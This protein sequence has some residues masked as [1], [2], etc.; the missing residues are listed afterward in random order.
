MGRGALVGIIIIVVIVLAALAWFASQQAQPQQPAAPT[1]AET[2][3]PAPTQGGPVV[4]YGQWAGVEGENFERAIS[5]Y[6]ESPVE[7]VIQEKIW[8]VV[9]QQLFAGNVQFDVALLPWPQRIVEL[10]ERGLL[11]PLDDVASRLEADLVNR[12][13]LEAVRGRDGSYYAVP[14]KMWAKPGI[15]VNVKAL[16][17][18]GLT[19][20]DVRTFEGLLAACEKLSA[21]GIQPLASGAADKWPLSDIWEHM[22][23]MLGGAELHDALTYDPAAWDRPEVRES[24]RLLAEMLKRGCF[25]DRDL[26]ISEKWEAQVPRLVKGEVAMYPMGNWITLFIAKSAEELGVTF[27]PGKDYVLVPWPSY[28]EGITQPIIAGGDWAIVP[29]NAPNKAAAIRFAE[30]LGGPEYQGA[31]VEAGG[32]LPTNKRVPSDV[33]SPVD[34]TILSLASER[35]V[36]VDL[37]DNIRPSE[38]QQEIWNALFELWANPDNWSQIFD[39]LKS[40][41]QSRMGGG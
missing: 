30:W 27:E 34:Q 25:G 40:T 26:R 22:L 28:R 13:F 38:L 41:V 33:M 39:G 35:G 15:W 7:Y 16:E 1:P 2:P 3:S 5:L 21:A 17:R 18:A 10:G 6:R 32:Y 19:P 36:V 23:I 24:F 11:E 37:D 9:T 29:K 31:M 14:I 4:I 8:D 20:D 12:Y